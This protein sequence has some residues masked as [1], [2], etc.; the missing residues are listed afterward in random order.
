MISQ[1]EKGAIF[2]FNEAVIAYKSNNFEGAVA[3]FSKAIAQ[4]PLYIKA[5][6]NRAK[7][8]IKLKEFKKALGDLNACIKDDPSNIQYWKYNG[9]CNMQVKNYPAAI[10]SYNKALD[11]DKSLLDIR[12]NRAIAFMNEGKHKNA[13]ED[14]KLISLQ[15]PD[16]TQVLFNLALCFSKTNN[17]DGALQA[18]EKLIDL[19]FKT[20]V[21]AKEKAKIHL[22]RKD[23][24]NAIKALDIAINSDNKD[25]ET[26]YLRGYCHLK[27][28]NLNSANLDFERSIA[29][30][31]VHKPSIQNKA[32]T[33]FKLENY[34]DAVSDFTKVL[35]LSP[36]DKDTRLNR[37]LS[38]LKLKKYNLAYLDFSKV[39][40]TEPN[41]AIAFY[42][43]ANA[44]IGLDKNNEACQDMRQAA[45][46]GYEEAFNHI[47]QICGNQ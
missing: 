38:S 46:L 9:Y 16:D 30:N 31:K 39:I 6:F 12:T 11:L 37:G 19:N 14:L 33:S 29:L 45:K 43:R 21:A 36:N 7:S 17:E 44:A 10:N 8:L 27:I 35:E 32:Y 26:F 13:L 24:P 40:S 1:T 47:R 5:R 15:K 23:Y 41:H 2:H 4:D 42:N 20:S 28:E 34:E 3:S 18:Y 22:N 25:F